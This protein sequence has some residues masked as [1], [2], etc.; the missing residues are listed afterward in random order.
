M[1]A[2][3]TNCCMRSTGNHQKK[4]TS[5]STEVLHLKASPSLAQALFARVQGRDTALYGS[6]QAGECARQ[7]HSIPLSLSGRTPTPAVGQLAHSPQHLPVGWELS[8]EGMKSSS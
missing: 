7:C 3:P 4:S 8:V 1:L 5:G 6:D 2:L